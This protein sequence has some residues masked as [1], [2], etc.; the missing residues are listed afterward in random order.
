MTLVLAALLADV[1]PLKDP[2][3]QS[4]TDRLIAPNADYLFGTDNFGRDVFSRILHGAQASFLIV[5]SSVALGTIIGSIIG[6]LSA[7]NGGITDTIIQRLT[8]AFLGFPLLVLAII[9]MI[10]LRP[11]VL[12]IA[13]A[14]TLVLIPQMIRLARSLTLTVI[15][16]DFI[17]S[18]LAK[19]FPI[20]RIAF[21]HIM[22]HISASI[23]TYAAGFAGVAIIAESTLNFLGLGVPPPYPTWGG[24]LQE[25]RQYMEGAPWLAIFPGAILSMAA[26]SFM[27][28]SDTLPEI[29]DR[30]NR[31]S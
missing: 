12:T 18:Y 13:T 11:S 10:A 22:P 31:S 21:N 27:F 1:L 7:L 3:L 25:S 8:D 9:L 4:A 24:M 6:V 30:R 19:G 17:K 29:F 15:Q 14:L 2:L 16:S 5:F 20:S 23:I 26:F 28:I